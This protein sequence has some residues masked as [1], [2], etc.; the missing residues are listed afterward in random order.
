MKNIVIVI[1]LL[2]IGGFIAVWVTN[3]QENHANETEELVDVE[4]DTSV[5]AE[6]N[7]DVTDE[8]VEVV[9]ETEYS[10]TLEDVT[11]EGTA[12]GEAKATVYSDES[13]ELSVTFSDLS[14]PED[15][16]FY[17]GWLVRSDP[18]DVISTGRVEKVDD[19]YVNNYK[20]EDNLSD[21]DQYVLTL[22]PDD[23]DEAPADHVLEGI[24]SIV[25]PTQ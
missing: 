19:S 9:A 6:T 7:S 12:I 17:E 11:D 21:Y 15:T 1:I 20:S 14:D 5:P 10:A 8:I 16:D 25:E 3:L 4:T 23:G 13:Y 24:F 2:V 22:E 18:S